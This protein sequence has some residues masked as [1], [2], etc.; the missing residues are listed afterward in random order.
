MLIKHGLDIN[1]VD[2]IHHEYRRGYSSYNESFSFKI[3]ALSGL[4]SKIRD[5]CDRVSFDQG[6]LKKEVDE[7]LRKEFDLRY[8]WVENYP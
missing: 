2:S 1:Y 3:I 8:P 7:R 6:K 4:S 5:I